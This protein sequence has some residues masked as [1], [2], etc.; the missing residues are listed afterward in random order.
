[1]Q[2]GTSGLLQQNSGPHHVRP[3]EA[4]GIEDRPIHV[5]FSRAIDDPFDTVFAQQPFNE[6]LISDISLH[7]HITRSPIEVL[8]IGRI[9][10][11]FERI[12][13]DHFVGALNHQTANQMRSDESRTAGHKDSHRESSGVTG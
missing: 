2:T 7:E 3:G 5:G 8:H 12:Q 13:I 4:P 6:Q 1:M 10:R 11:I 9:T